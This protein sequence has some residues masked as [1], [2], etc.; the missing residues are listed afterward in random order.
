MLLSKKLIY[1]FILLIS[2][3]SCQKKKIQSEDK[4]VPVEYFLTAEDKTIF[5]V[6]K[7]NMFIQYR[8]SLNNTLDF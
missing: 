1:T 3:V 8:D 7:N 6:F 4:I 5:E 2:L